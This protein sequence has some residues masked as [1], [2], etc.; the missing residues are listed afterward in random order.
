MTTPTQ[1]RLRQARLREGFV[2][3]PSVAFQ[4]IGVAGA[5]VVSTKALPGGRSGLAQARRLARKSGGP[6]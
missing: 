5:A 1:V 4:S 2:C 3:T 6:A